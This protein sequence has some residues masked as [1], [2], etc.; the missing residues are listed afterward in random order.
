[1]KWWDA[2]INKLRYCS[3]EKFDEHNNKFGKGWPPG[4]NM[5]NVKNT[6]DLQTIKLI[7]LANLSLKK[8]YLKKHSNFRQGA[9]RL[10]SLIIIVSIITLLIS[11]NKITIV[12]VIKPSLKDR[13][14]MYGFLFLI[15]IF[16]HSTTGH[17]R[18]IRSA[19]LGK[20]L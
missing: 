16:N 18:C 4:S 2:H 6:P 11:L 15:K 1:M 19:T 3:S 7:F 17:G 5:L 20:Y 12:H 9:L 13:E 8:R 10:T 14:S